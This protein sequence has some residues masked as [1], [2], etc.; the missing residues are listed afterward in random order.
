LNAWKT[1]ENSEVEDKTTAMKKIKKRW[2]MAV[3]NKT[4]QTFLN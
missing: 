3:V 4:K 2:R 1:K